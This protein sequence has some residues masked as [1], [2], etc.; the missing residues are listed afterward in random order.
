MTFLP[1]SLFLLDL[2]MMYI[3]SF[4]LPFDCVGI[5]IGNKSYNRQ[6]IKMRFGVILRIVD[7]VVLGLCRSWFG[8]V[9]CGV[10]KCEYM[11]SFLVL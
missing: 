7:H 10:L 6:R 8:H 11:V 3:L 9:N 2:F 4:I 5:L 1:V